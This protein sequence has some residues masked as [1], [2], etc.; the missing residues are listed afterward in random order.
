[1]VAGETIA[2][3]WSRESFQDRV[4]RFW[5]SSP[6]GVFLWICS[7]YFAVK[8]YLCLPTPGKAIGALAVVAGIMS[9]RDMKV[10]AKISWVV[11]LIFMLIT[12]FRAIDK[13]HA[14]N[15]EKQRI[16][17]KTQKQGFQ[18]IANQADENFKETAKGLD[19][20][21]KSLNKVV[22]NITGGDDF[23]YIVPTSGVLTGLP[24][25]SSFSMVL[26]NNGD[27]ILSGITVRISALRCDNP[28]DDLNPS[29][30]YSS[31]GGSFHPYEMGTLGPKSKATIPQFLTTRINPPR[32]DHYRMR[33]TAQNGD[34]VEDFWCRPAKIGPGI[35]YKFEVVKIVRGKHLKGDFLEG[36]YWMRNLKKQDWTES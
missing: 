1:M 29:C 22:G 15:E 21:I 28:N 18:D 24:Y 35:A 6:M 26:I 30:A 25:G 34:S 32:V 23:A 16:F 20:S 11:L 7:A 13:D 8:W 14:D 31:S 2:D 27:E 12:E 9:V 19:A 17:F 33:I 5:N 10:V 4:L 36:G 3:M